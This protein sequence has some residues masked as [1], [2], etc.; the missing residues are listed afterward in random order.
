MKLWLRNLLLGVGLGLLAAM[1]AGA[2]WEVIIEA[3]D[4]GDYATA[5]RELKLLSKQGDALAQYNFGLMHDNGKGVPEDDTEAAKW[6]LRAAEQGVVDAQFNLGNMYSKGEGVSKDDAEAVKWYR[7]A[8]EQ[9]FA[10]AQ[11]NLGTLYDKGEGVPEDNVL[12][13]HW[14]NLAA[15]QGDEKSKGNKAKIR[16]KMTAEQ[17]AEAQKLSREFKAK[18]EYRGLDFL[19]F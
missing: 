17:I 2:D 19:R 7:R 1:P 12:A 13:Y 16:D 8:A 15:A 9:G 4:A 3:F 14:Y 5:S 6:Y 18:K 10:K 11:N